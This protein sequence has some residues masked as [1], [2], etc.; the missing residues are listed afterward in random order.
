VLELP[1]GWGSPTVVSSAPWC[2]PPLLFL[3]THYTTLCSCAKYLLYIYTTLCDWLTCARDHA[4]S[5][6]CERVAVVKNYG[7]FAYGTLR[8]LDS[9]PTAW[10]FR[11]LDTSPTGHFAYESFRLLDNLA[12]GQF[13]C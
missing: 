6:K 13:A 2:R 10:S 5:V 8:L 7:H 11:L 9:L 1:G 4:V 3:N 12:I